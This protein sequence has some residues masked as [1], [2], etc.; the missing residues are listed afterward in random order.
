VPARPGEVN[1][2]GAPGERGVRRSR[3]IPGVSEPSPRFHIVLVEPRIPQ[4][5][6]TIGRL[7]VAAGARLHLVGP[8][9]FDLDDPRRR[10]AGLDY[11]PDLRWTAYDDLAH[12]LRAADPPEP[13]CWYTAARGGSPYT[14]ARFHAGDWIF[15][16]AETEGLPGA[17]IEGHE[18]RCLTIPMDPRARSINLAIAVGIVVYE[19]LRQTGWPPATEATFS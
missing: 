10:R 13:R 16:G 5:T 19:G 18:A 1:S 4:N 17:L 12:F 7:C 3:Y 14:D 9:G 8:L 2:S 6:G 15:F 11:W